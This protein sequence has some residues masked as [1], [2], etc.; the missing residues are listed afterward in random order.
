MFLLV[1]YGKVFCSTA[2][3]LPQNSDAFSK[4]DSIPGLLTVLR[5]IH[6]VQD[7]AYI[8]P[9]WPLFLLSDIRDSR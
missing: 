4:E 2:N 7:A 8:R 5:Q 6:H 3:E 1:D 9:L